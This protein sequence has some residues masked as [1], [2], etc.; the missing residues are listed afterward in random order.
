MARTYILGL[1]CHKHT[2]SSYVP[3]P[4]EVASAA[5]AAAVAA[6]VDAAVDAALA[7][8][9]AAALPPPDWA[10]DELA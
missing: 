4:V 10:E 5:V 1:Q 8:T 3:A 7:P 2:V 9:V 6:A